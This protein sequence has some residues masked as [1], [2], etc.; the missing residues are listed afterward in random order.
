[1]TETATQPMLSATASWLRFARNVAIV[2]V[3]W[4]V[5]VHLTARILIP[6]VLIIGLVFLAFVPFLR[7]ERRWVAIGFAAFALLAVVGNIPGL[8]DELSNPESAPAFVLTLLSFLGAVLAVVSGTAAFFAW[9]PEPARMIAIGA[10]G[11]FVVGAVISVAMFATTDSDAAL[12]SDVEVVA[13]KVLWEP[14]AVVMTAGASGVW[15]DNKD[16]IRHT[17]TIEELGIDLEIPA[18]K[19]KRVDIAGAPGTYEITCEVP[20]HENMTGT[21]TIEG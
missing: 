3:V 14:E 17:F 9:S 20:G 8:V 1:M 16:G 5:L 2:M 15:V 11:V 7:G 18:L 21:L 19:A 4:A 6:P 12:A 13:E 10:T